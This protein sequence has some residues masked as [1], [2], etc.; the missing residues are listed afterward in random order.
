[1]Q[2]VFPP[3]IEWDY[4]DM[5]I[6]AYNSKLAQSQ[7]CMLKYVNHASKLSV[8]LKRANEGNIG[9]EFWVRNF[10]AIYVNFPTV[11][12]R[13]KVVSKVSKNQKLICSYDYR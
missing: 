11:P 2:Q 1:M 3:Y 4:E 8:F 7:C 13:Y 6:I 9:E 12:F 5:R 10:V